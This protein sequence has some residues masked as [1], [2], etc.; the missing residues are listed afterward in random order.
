MEIE[1]QAD[2]T[3]EQTANQKP[4][5]QASKRKSSTRNATVYEKIPLPI[6][7]YTPSAVECIAYDQQHHL[8]AIARSNSSFEV[9]NY[10]DWT[11]LAV[12]PCSRQCAIR[13]LAFLNNQPSPILL[14][15]S[16]NCLLSLY[17][18]Q[19]LEPFYVKTTSGNAIWDMQVNRE[20]EIALAFDDGTVKIHSYDADE[21]GLLFERT[22]KPH[23][24]KALSVAWD[25]TLK[26]IY[27]GFL[28]GKV[29]KYDRKSGAV[30]FTINLKNYE[31][32]WSLQCLPSGEV[33]AIGTSEGYTYFYE[34]SYGTMI[35][36]LKTHEADVLCLEVSASANP[37]P[38]QTTHEETVYASG[39]DSKVVAIQCVTEEGDMGETVT[40][41]WVQSSSDRGQS[42]DIRALCLVAG[43]NEL[44]SGGL[45]TDICIYKLIKGN[46]RTR[47]QLQAKTGESKLNTEIKL[48]HI[49]ALPMRKVV[50]VANEKNLFLFQF[51]FSLE[52]WEFI[53]DENEFNFLIELK[54]KDLPVITS[55]LS[56]SGT[57]LAYSTNEETH[58]FA[59]NPKDSSLRKSGALKPSSCLA[60][61]HSGSQLFR[62]DYEG[63]TY[64]RVEV[65]AGSNT[66]PF[67][68]VVTVE[69]EQ[70]GVYQ[71]A[72]VS[73]TRELVVVGS[74]LCNRI[75]IQQ[76]E[77]KR[78]KKLD[79]V[80][81]LFE[82]SVYTCFKITK[83]NDLLLIAYANNKFAF[84]N[85]NDGV[86]TKWSR[87]HMEAFPSNYLNRY[88]RII[89]AVFDPN[90]T[91]NMVL[92]TH[93]YMIRV[94]LN[95]KIPQR[96]DVAKSQQQ[97]PGG[98][99]KDGKHSN[100]QISSFAN[101][102]LALDFL[103]QKQLLSVSA[104]WKE[105]A[106]RFPDAVNAKRYGL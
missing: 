64:E 80:P 29:R 97:K 6:P 49:G 63:Q 19:S 60:L 57:L 92:H 69:L 105:I 46:L 37:D 73:A 106:A 18:L 84:Y 82:N 21:E 91:S 71:D 34:T 75:F 77:L 88:N 51:D 22:F 72:D 95:Q 98:K 30:L 47:R 38:S 61:S 8:V 94:Y 41:K 44:L 35:S 48:R 9:W 3:N 54:T 70:T 24:E 16:N 79:T 76:G 55:A 7:N 33:L 25:P 65:I 104:N 1:N 102:T 74:K 14:V 4:D 99:S 59:I 2:Q 36:E 27:A 32:V 56:R 17:N 42:H 86:F 96:S 39:A 31:V 10:A 13:R 20:N 90:N 40:S 81:Q 101:P 58:V 43:K 45:T 53:Y 26:Y 11:M 52:L 50:S 28:N 93:Y 78:T 89:G 100:F 15:A 85:I 67:R 68:G 23:L 12:F 5:V 103:N 66:K 87:E 83:Q 62:V